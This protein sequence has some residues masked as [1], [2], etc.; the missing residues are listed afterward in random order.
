MRKRLM[1]LPLFVLAFSAMVVALP[2]DQQQRTCAD[3][4][5]PIIDDPAIPDY[6]DI[7]DNYMAC[8]GSIEIIPGCIDERADNYDPVAT[9]DDGSCIY[10]LVYI[11][12]TKE[13]K[14]FIYNFT[15]SSQAFVD[16]LTYACTDATGY[17][18]SVYR[19]RPYVGSNYFACLVYIGEPGRYYR[20]M[21]WQI[22]FKSTTSG[23]YDGVRYYSFY[24]QYYVP[25]AKFPLPV[26]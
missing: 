7:V 19:V 13:Y 4:L 21:L 23:Q 12:T 18:D 1:A 17:P 3:M 6:I 20:P 9:V 15:G 5:R 8:M 10:S 24:P 14:N 22:G 11:N 25:D 16:A 2:V 26:V